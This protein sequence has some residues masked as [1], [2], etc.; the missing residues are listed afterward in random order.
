MNTLLSDLNQNVGKVAWQ[1]YTLR[2]GIETIEV[3]VPLV[4]AP[5]FEL[6]MR[7]PHPSK[8]AALETLRGCG[9]E[10]K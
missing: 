9:G 3:L 10:L 8:Q 6:Q 7:M 4:H 5:R 1:A 2:H